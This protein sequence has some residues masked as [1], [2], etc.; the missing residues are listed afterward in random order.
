MNPERENLPLDKRSWTRPDA[1]TTTNTTKDG[2]NAP[3]FA[4]PS[5]NS[6]RKPLFCNRG[7]ERATGQDLGP[8]F[9]AS[10][11]LGKE[12]PVHSSNLVTRQSATISNTGDSQ[13]LTPSIAHL[14]FPHD[15]YH[16]QIFDPH[17][18]KVPDRGIDALNE[19]Y[20]YVK[21]PRPIIK[22]LATTP[23]SHPVTPGVQL[24][25]IPAYHVLNEHQVP[26][27]V[28][29][30]YI[31]EGLLWPDERSQGDYLA[32][33]VNTQS[34]GG[35]MTALGFSG[36]YP[37]YSGED[38]RPL[39]DHDGYLASSSPQDSDALLMGYEAYLKAHQQELLQAEKRWQDS[40]L[41]EWK[42]GKTGRCS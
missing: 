40:T 15:S 4:V 17:E 35:N 18:L 13:C 27:Q 36:S 19:S 23:V 33:D 20:H 9:Q 25:P 1:G 2:M 5:I 42:A 38:G 37:H 8:R 10:A 31:T 7:G 3:R 24:N 11:S 12:S 26:D 28:R 41:E 22:Q 16:R 6:T 14:S 39:N 30:R 21:N 32:M 34:G 29:E